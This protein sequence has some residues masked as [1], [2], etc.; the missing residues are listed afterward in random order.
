M[1]AVARSEQ[2]FKLEFT[3][4]WILQFTEENPMFCVQTGLSSQ[5]V[6]F[7]SVSVS[8]GRNDPHPIVPSA[9]TGQTEGF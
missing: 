7:N 4:L 3:P 1:Q 9:K 5:T 2:D 8:Q 6:L